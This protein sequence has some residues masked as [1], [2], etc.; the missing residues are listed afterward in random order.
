MSPKKGVS[1][2]I[3]FDSQADSVSVLF[4]RLFSGTLAV[5]FVLLAS[6][7]AWT[8]VFGSYGDIGYWKVYN[9]RRGKA[10]ALLAKPSTELPELWMIGSSTSYPLLPKDVEERFGRRTY[11][12][13]NYWARMTENWS[14]LNFI[15]RDLAQKPDMIILGLET[16]TFRPDSDGPF[17]YPRIRRRLI[18]TPILFQYV[19]EY[20]P[21]RV[22]LSKIFDLISYQHLQ[23]GLEAL[24]TGE[25]R[26]GFRNTDQNTED[27]NS[28]GS[29]P[30]GEEKPDEFFAPI[31]INEFYRKLHRGDIHLDERETA[32]AH[33][34]YMARTDVVIQKELDTFF[35]G[36]DFDARE[37]ALFSRFVEL[38]EAHSI[39]LII[40][41][42]PTHPYY[43]DKLLRHTEHERHLRSLRALAAKTTAGRAM[44][45]M[46]FDASD[47]R[48]FGG[49]PIAFHDMYH[50]KPSNG[51]RLL[52]HALKRW[53]NP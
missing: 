26:T 38:C 9:D 49:D 33:E 19:D 32:Q 50:M 28:D 21:G 47:L 40:L 29:G 1:E 52:D 3:I 22:I 39:P 5:G 13:V 18:N 24:M 53:R 10:E 44:K 37:V 27:F 16:W 43:H 6:F 15:L 23:F 46:V 45:T 25:K 12:V 31:Q 2:L 48:E 42:M 17:I 41:L 7:I 14:W 20:H 35:P 36:E 8:N 11:T 51:R 34:R 4:L 30:Y